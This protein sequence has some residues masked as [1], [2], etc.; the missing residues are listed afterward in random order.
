MVTAMLSFR[1]ALLLFLVLV[2]PSNGF[3]QQNEGGS[4]HDSLFLPND[5]DKKL[6][7][8][9]EIDA[10]VRASQKRAAE[11]RLQNERIISSIISASVTIVGTCFIVWIVFT[12]KARL[13]KD[14]RQIMHRVG[15][16]YYLR[17]F[18]VSL[19]A[20]VFW[21]VLLLFTNSFQFEYIF[22]MSGSDEN[23]FRA[24]AI[25]PPLLCVVAYFF[26]KWAMR[27]RK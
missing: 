16:I 8:F 27:G 2:P 12:D 10:A 25:L 5:S 18:R 13:F 9:E 24:L 14:C 20:Y 23:R 21:L 19:S 22:N 26:I 11:E 17:S 1:V 3:S 4:L 7:T 6:L 15:G